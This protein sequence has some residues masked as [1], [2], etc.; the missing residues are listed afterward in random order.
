[1]MNPMPK[2]KK[3]GMAKRIG[4][5]KMYGEKLTVELKPKSAA[6]RLSGVR[7]ARSASPTVRRPKKANPKV[8]QGNMINA[9]GN[10]VMAKS[11]ADS[12]STSAVRTP[13]L[14]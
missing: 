1:M 6:L 9:V 10:A 4:V 8:M 2:P 13:F 11:E 7:S 14:P 5:R 3:L 12:I